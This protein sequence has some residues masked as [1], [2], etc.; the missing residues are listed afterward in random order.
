MG[1]EALIAP[2]QKIVLST[3][4]S[5]ARA[6]ARQGLATYLLLP[7][8]TNNFLRLGF[9]EDDL[10]DGG[11]DRLIDG[12]FAWGDEAT[13]A[14]R[15]RA[16]HDAGADHVCVQVLTAAGHTATATDL[17]ESWQRVAAALG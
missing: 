13:A 16:H 1:P 4:P 14:E 2:D 11:S 7:N 17:L 15:V 6:I 3:D 8:Y 10:A 5:E 12:L 9:T